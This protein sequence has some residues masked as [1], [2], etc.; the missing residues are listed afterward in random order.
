MKKKH[1]YVWRKY[2]QPWTL[3]DKIW[4]LHNNEIRFDNLINIAAQNYFFSVNDLS[5][6]EIIL[7]KKLW[8]DKAPDFIKELHSNW[9]KMF[10]YVLSFRE[11]SS[12]QEFPKEFQG[13]Y[14]NKILS[15][16]EDIQ[17]KIE[18]SSIQFF[19]KIKNDDI[20]FYKITE[21]NA[22]FNYFLAVQYLRTKK[23]KNNMLDIVKNHNSAKNVN[24][25]NVWNIGM[26]IMATNLSFGLHKEMSSLN[27]VILNNNNPIDFL[28]GDQ[29]IIN[30]FGD[31]SKKQQELNH[32]ALELYYPI[33]PNKAI[34]I[35]KQEKYNDKKTVSVNEDDV[36]A[37]NNLI[38][39]A[40]EL[41]IFSKEN[42]QLEIY[43]N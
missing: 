3:K 32:D 12:K 40:S 27:M 39:Q 14:E 28:T 30:T 23:I 29:P 37:Y 36:I 25:E 34:L 38:Y 16:E 10:E 1:H 15:F 24:F 13:Q 11:R 26:L 9:L 17:S 4:V 20:D 33:T 5:K 22:S 21:N 7:I 8:I 6:E 2:L 43:L 41:Q 18:S 31:Y 42:K 35:S 19:D